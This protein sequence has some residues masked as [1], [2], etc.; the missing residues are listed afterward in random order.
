M[1]NRWVL[2][3]KDFE[4]FNV[5]VYI[6]SYKTDKY[7]DVETFHVTSDINKAQKFAKKKA[8]R[9]SDE[10]YL[11]FCDDFNVIEVQNARRTI[12]VRMD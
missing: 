5:D 7:G 8:L 6:E 2:K 10:I 11:S 1:E 12:M 4:N 9:L 3:C